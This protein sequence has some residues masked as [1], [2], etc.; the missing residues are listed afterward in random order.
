[1]V[2]PCVN[3]LPKST[4]APSSCSGYLEDDSL[5]KRRVGRESR[6]GPPW[7]HQC[8]CLKKH[9]YELPCSLCLVTPCPLLRCDLTRRPSQMCVQMAWMWKYIIPCFQLFYE[10]GKFYNKKSK[11]KV[12]CDTRV[13]NREEADAQDSPGPDQAQ[14]TPHSYFSG[15]GRLIL[16]SEI[17]LCYNREI[18]GRLALASHPTC[19]IFFSKQQKHTEVGVTN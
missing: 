14:T 11:I 4:C 7:W 9:S 18:K 17:W 19:S 15:Q 10:Q 13:L 16:T 5:E 12:S 3:V 6:A 2:W 8:L 1:M